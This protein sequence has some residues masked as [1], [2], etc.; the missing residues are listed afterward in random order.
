MN[1]KDGMLTSEMS[2]TEMRPEAQARRLELLAA[3]CTAGSCPTVYLTDRGTVVVQGYAFEGKD[4]GV[5]PPPGEL[6]VEIPAELLAAAVRN[7][8]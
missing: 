2:E 8:S 4:A 1:T 7:Q 5:T 6:L 3:S